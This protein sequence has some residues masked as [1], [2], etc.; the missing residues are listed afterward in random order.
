MKNLS[1][2]EMKKVIGGIYYPPPGSS[3]CSIKCADGTIGTQDCEN[4][5]DCVA[6][7]DSDSVLC[8]STEYCVCDGHD[9]PNT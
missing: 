4:G 5:V 1:K 2:D 8:G 6:S 9:I 7:P 3:S